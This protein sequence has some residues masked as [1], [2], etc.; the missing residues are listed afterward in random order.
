MALH[1]DQA[2][3]WNEKPPIGEL[4]TFHGLDSIVTHELSKTAGGESTHPSQLPNS[5]LGEHGLL[6]FSVPYY[7]DS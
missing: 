6:P 4:W 2:I 1:R 7:T 5:G 3:L